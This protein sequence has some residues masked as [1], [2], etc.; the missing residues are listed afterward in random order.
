VD[1]SNH[2]GTVLNGVAGL[3]TASRA[4]N[5]GSSDKF[6]SAWQTANYASSLSGAAVVTSA[7]GST[8][9][10]ATT[11]NLGSG[12]STYWFNGYISRVTLWNTMHARVE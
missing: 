8:M 12:S 11:F 7:S 4:F 10:N 9:N 6:I 5:I 2:A 1:N 3:A